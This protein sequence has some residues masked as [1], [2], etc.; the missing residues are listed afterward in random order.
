SEASFSQISCEV[1]DLPDFVVG[2]G[3]GDFCATGFAVLA[4][5]AAG[6]FALFKAGGVTCGSAGEHDRT[7]LPAIDQTKPIRSQL[8][9]FRW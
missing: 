7:R 4:I 6:A 9:V 2:P 8:R 1:S 3:F 5:G